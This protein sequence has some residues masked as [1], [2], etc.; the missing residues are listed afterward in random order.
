M[1]TGRVPVQRTIERPR[2]NSRQICKTQELTEDVWRFSAL[3]RLDEMGR[4][5]NDEIVKVAFS[6][7]DETANRL[8]SSSAPAWTSDI[9]K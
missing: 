7:A 1:D 8:K 6:V 2:S 5:E 9:A 3:E 4:H